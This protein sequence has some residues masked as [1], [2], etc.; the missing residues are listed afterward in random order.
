[1]DTTEAYVDRAERCAQ[2]AGDEGDPNIERYWQREAQIHATLAL[3]AA[4]VDVR[5]ALEARGADNQDEIDR[6]I[7]EHEVAIFN[8]PS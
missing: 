8:D 2:L 6:A 5:E 1:M 4:V 7:A 3:V